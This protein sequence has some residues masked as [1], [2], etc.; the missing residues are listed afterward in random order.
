MK[1][2]LLLTLLVL[3]SSLTFSKAI[4]INPGLVFVSQQVR[5]GVLVWNG[6]MIIG[7]P[8]FVFFDKIS[9]RGQ[10]GL[11]LQHTVGV[12]QFRLGIMIFDD[13]A[14]QGP[15]IELGSEKEDY[16]NLRQ[17]TFESTFTYTYNQ[18]GRFSAQL[19]ASKDHKNN[20]HYFSLSSNISPFPLWRVGTTFGFG[21]SKQNRY[22]YGPEGKGGLGHY[23]FFTS[24]MI[25]WILPKKG[26]LIMRYTRSQVAR[27][28][29]RHSFFTR[30]EY[31]HDT[32]FTGAFWRL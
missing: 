14:P 16:K 10:D 5:R 20:G 31:K 18:R 6:S 7:G 13:S 11:S 24:Y 1:K 3:I 4:Q 22:L 2:I 17:A 15:V 9:L 19:S 8:S 29:N 28:V 23:D 30:G 27:G 32:F 26:V 12:H 25:P 21:N